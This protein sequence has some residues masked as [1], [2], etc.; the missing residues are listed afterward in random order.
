MFLCSGGATMPEIQEQGQ[1]NQE[2]GQDN[3][4][5]TYLWIAGAVGAAAGIAALAYSRRRETTWDKARRRA[6]DIADAARDIELK[7]WMGVA[8][9]AA[10]GTAG[11]AA[12]K[13]R[14]KP[15][16]WERVGQQASDM[17]GQARESMQPW[18]ALVAS[19]AVSAISLARNR[20]RR[21]QASDSVRESATEAAQAI[22]ETGARLFRRVQNLSGETRRLY[23]R[24]RKLIA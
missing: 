7:P 12:Y 11:L 24:V 8:A 18:M 23:P 16:T 15:T 13:M 1:L 17:A 10:A 20:K 2:Q 6:G 9:G 14:H 4:V 22:A 21:A 19:A 3:N 5:G